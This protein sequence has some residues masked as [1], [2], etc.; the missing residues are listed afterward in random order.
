MYDPFAISIAKLF[1]FREVLVPAEWA[2][3]THLYVKFPYHHENK[4]KTDPIY[5]SAN[6]ENSNK[7]TTKIDLTG[8]SI[9]TLQPRELHPIAAPAI[10]RRSYRTNLSKSRRTATVCPRETGGP[11]K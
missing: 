10:S 6:D 2:P 1:L 7:D 5:D 3:W 4:G 8:I 11:S 9:L